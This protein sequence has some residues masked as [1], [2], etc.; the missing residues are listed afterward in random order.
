MDNQNN[1]TITSANASLFIT[2]PG[3]YDSPVKIENYST[4]AMVSAAQ[5]NPVVAEMGVDGHLSVGYTPTPKEITIT[6]AADSKSRP[7]FDDW[8]AYQ[9]AAKEVYVCSAQFIVP[10]IGKTF[11][12]LRG[13]LTAAQPMPNAAKTL[14]APAYNI[15]FESW[16]PSSL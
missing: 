6:L 8:Q 5:V 3:L 11:T 13:A 9:D 7:V 4:D 14:Q 2:V 12:G 16:T 10:G 1:Q 15:T